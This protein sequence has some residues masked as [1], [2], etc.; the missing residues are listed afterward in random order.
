VR[1]L[2]IDQ[3]SGAKDV[4]DG[5][6]SFDW[7][8]LRDHS[9]EALLQREGVPAV[10]ARDLYDGRQQRLIDS[11]VDRL[12]GAGHTVDRMFV[13]AGFG[14]IDEETALPPYD[15]TFNDLS[16]AAIDDRAATLGIHDRVLDLLTA[17][18]PYDLAFLPLGSDYYRASRIE[19]VLAELPAE[20]TVV[21]FNAEETVAG[22]ENAMSLPARTSE[23]KKHGTIVVALKGQYLHNF[24]THLEAGATVEGSADIEDYCTREYTQQAGLDDYGSADG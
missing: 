2:I 18:E 12:R 3:C 22:Y 10:R 19:A 6:K 9:R 1:L 21:L 17:G 13:S 20:T 15:T 4:P 24:A 5:A 7:E 23:A 11:A 8:T 14:V 16:T